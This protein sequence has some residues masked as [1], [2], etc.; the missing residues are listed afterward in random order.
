ME[1]ENL[2]FKVELRAHYKK[3]EAKEK[4]LE[5]I[6]SF[7]KSCK[8]ENKRNITDFI[9]EIID[10][11]PCS[12]INKRCFEHISKNVVSSVNLLENELKIYN[13]NEEDKRKIEIFK[14]GDITILKELTVEKG[15]RIEVTQCFDM[16]GSELFMKETNGDKES[17][18]IAG[19][20]FE[21]ENK[22]S[23]LTRDLK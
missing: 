12:K 2:N 10:N 21:K 13:R 15:N 22:I 14:Q 20:V 7:L 19:N 9:F 8:L 1:S 18:S 16:N 6:S 23:K 11:N 4:L 5:S 3:L 17:L